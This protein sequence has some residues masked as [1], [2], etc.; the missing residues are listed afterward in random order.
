MANRRKK[1][2]ELSCDD[3]KA[4]KAA[5]DHARD[6]GHPLNT[7]LTFVPYYDALVSPSPADIAATFKRLLTYLSTWTWRNTRCRLTFI[8]IAHSDD[9]GSGRNPHLHI[10][11]HLPAKYR[12]ALQAALTNLY[13][14]T[15]AGGLVAMVRNGFEPVRHES[16]YW[17]S[18]FDYMT[19]HKTQQAFIAGGGL[20]S[21][22]GRSWRASR[23]DEKGRHV[24][25][26]CPFIGRRWNVSRNLN[27]KDRQD[28]R[29]MLAAERA[30]L[31]IAAERR[32][33]AA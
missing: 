31:R 6:I 14:Y 20:S 1:T 32:K 28:H 33:L 9:D 3:I 23:R 22:P 18:S 12:D 2:T 16:G 4:L 5:K 19:R 29:A 24:G 11:M 30:P 27:A 10:L 15:A 17:G 13:G 26:K 25:I 8:R 7:H 21:R